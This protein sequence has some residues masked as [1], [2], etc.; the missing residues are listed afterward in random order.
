MKFCPFLVAGSSLTEPQSK[1]VAFEGVADSPTA[2]TSSASPTAHLECL[3]EP[4]RFFH[5]GGCRFDTMFT[6]WEA[7]ATSPVIAG[8]PVA[9]GEP[10]VSSQSILA[11]IPAILEEVWS[12]QRESLREV[13]GGF[14]K[15]EATQVELKQ[16]LAQGPISAVASQVGQKVE[17]EVARVE[18]VVGRVESQLGQL[19][20]S[21]ASQLM[22]QS[23]V[24]GE[25]RATP[26]HP[27]LVA[28]LGQRF[29]AL[30]RDVRRV[31]D[32]LH[33]SLGES[34]AS[35]R[36]QLVE[37]NGTQRSLQ[38]TLTAIQATLAE[39]KLLAQ[40]TADADAG[41]QL[42]EIQNV[43]QSRVQD[44]QN[45]VQARVQEA[46]SVVQGAVRELHAATLA[47]V[48]GTE[49]SLR[50]VLEKLQGTVTASGQEGQA[51][52]RTTNAEAQTQL[53]SL[54]ARVSTETRNQLE[55]GLGKVLEE[56]VQVR[57]AR[58]QIQAA[59]DSL[60]RE[61]REVAVLA[62][63]VESSQVLTHEL[64]DEQ[65]QMTSKLD[66]RERRERARQLNNAGVL[67]YHQA[68]YD[69]SVERFKQATELDPNLAEAFNNL[70][71]SYTEMSRDDEATAAFQ[72]A[73]E[74]DPSIGNVYNNLGYLYYRKGDL[75]HAIEM[76]QR[77]I[78]RG[79]DTSAAYSNLA[80]AYYKMKR[81]DAAVSAW[82][83]AVEIDPSNHK[84]QAALERLGLETRPS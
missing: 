17:S 76:Y 36:A 59:L 16:G 35:L 66:L 34:G 10:V 4:C 71:L 62:R 50:G 2:A 64:L 73:L 78:Q 33:S 23:R 81:F 74:I 80:N 11:S 82:R 12:L 32:A 67:C 7:R 77:A 28:L 53:G 46:Q 20:A 56:M 22:A 63:R 41:V 37:S 19:D 69:A 29:E 68:A 49:T 13:M 1:S 3:G 48:A 45:V 30:E 43:V 47:A 14:Q 39:T 84:A 31:E 60:T 51:L 21:L 27:E 61:T 75:D 52:L 38:D 26:P 44:V 57:D 40:R 58:I 72:R 42:R 55:R 18:A 9:S 25:V 24:L 54:V 5:A 79:S 6:S 65:R 70:G 8:E 83:H 15:I